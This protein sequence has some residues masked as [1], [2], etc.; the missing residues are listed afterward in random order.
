[1]D[2]ARLVKGPGLAHKN[3]DWLQIS[4]EIFWANSPGMRFL[5]CVWRPNKNIASQQE[6]A[7]YY[8]YTQINTSTVLLREFVYFYFVEW[9]KKI[10]FTLS[11][12]IGL[13][14]MIKAARFVIL[15]TTAI[16]LR[17]TS[18]ER[19]HNEKLSISTPSW[20]SPRGSGWGC[21][22]LPEQTLTLFFYFENSS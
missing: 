10:Y 9:E 19:N 15:S 1:M 4:S 16:L 18:G 20:I 2:L 14:I 22:S 5:L 21:K 3:V 6:T 8:I 17:S 12:L 11:S 7:V 13:S